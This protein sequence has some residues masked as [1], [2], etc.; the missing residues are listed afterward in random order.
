MMISGL[1]SW[2]CLFRGFFLM[3]VFCW[4][5][6]ASGTSCHVLD[7]NERS[8]QPIG[9]ERESSIRRRVRINADIESG[10]DGN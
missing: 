2:C 1:S 7:R 5:G 4:N 9:N 3:D 8:R 6:L 10:G